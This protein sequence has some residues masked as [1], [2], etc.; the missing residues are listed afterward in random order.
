MAIEGV[1]YSWDRP[2]PHTLYTAGKRFA[3]RYLSYDTTGKNLTYAESNALFHAGL[4]VVCNWEYNVHDA[5]G[6]H[7]TGVTHAHSA[8]VEATSVGKP[9]GRP[10]YFSVDFDA[11][12]A[13]LVKVAAY[14]RGCADE[15]GV[16]NV[17]VYGGYNTIDYCYKHKVA[18]WFWQTYAWSGSKIHKQAHI[19]QYSN[20]HVIGGGKV[21]YDRAIKADFGQWNLV[22]PNPVTDPPPPPPLP[23]S[24]GWDYTDIITGT[25][26]QFL[27]VG[28]KLDQQTTLINGV[29]NN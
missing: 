28:T 4:S 5:L 23:Q 26:S 9:P 14:L 15:I 21:D 2:N 3:I 25:A 16:Y 27:S 19:Y 8:W 13:Q 18:D 10:I 17:G 24:S 6:D 7:D 11:S 29:R 12:A 20:G 1:D 22:D